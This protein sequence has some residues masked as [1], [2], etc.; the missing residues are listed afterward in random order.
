MIGEFAVEFAPRNA[1]DSA[2]KGIVI[3]VSVV[4]TIRIFFKTHI[5]F[6]R[7][8]IEKFGKQFCKTVYYMLL[9]SQNS[10]SRQLV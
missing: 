9:S 6:P 5:Y 8:S 2:L 7:S 3:A 10:A 4:N 1:R